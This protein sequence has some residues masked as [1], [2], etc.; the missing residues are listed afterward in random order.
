MVSYWNLGS[1]ALPFQFNNFMVMVLFFMKIVR[2]K[3]V[4]LHS[5]PFLQVKHKG[6]VNNPIFYCYLCIFFSL[7]ANTNVHCIYFFWAP[8]LNLFYFRSVGLGLWVVRC[9][10][11]SLSIC[12]CMPILVRAWSLGIHSME[13]PP[14]CPVMATMEPSMGQPWEPTVM[15]WPARHIVLMV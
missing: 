5:G 8:F 7:R 6:C 14:I 11:L 15:E 9:F 13:M 4:F 2:E 3:S 12:P 10:S 1:K